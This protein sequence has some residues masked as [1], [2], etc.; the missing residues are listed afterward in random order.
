MV[1]GFGA[2]EVE[3]PLVD[4]RPLDDGCEALEHA[5]DRTARVTA[6]L[7]RHRNAHRV[8]AEAK[9]LRD[10]HRRSH[11]ERA[12]L[13]RRRADD[14]AA[15]GPSAHDQQ[16]SLAGSLGIDRAG[17]RDEE[18]V[19]VGE[20]YS[21]HPQRYKIEWGRAAVAARPHSSIPSRSS[22][23]SSMITTRRFSARPA[24]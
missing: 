18:R 22:Y 1:E 10:R 15:S 21:G 24:G 11:A 3:V 16:R 23:G 12:R 4:A 7:A 19:G 6:R 5:A 2:A 13:V 20:E 17:H 8:G 9:R 14:S